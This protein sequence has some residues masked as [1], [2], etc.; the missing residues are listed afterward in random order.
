MSLVQISALWSLD[1]IKDNYYFDTETFN[2][3]NMDTNRILKPYIDKRGYYAV[4]L[5]R[6]YPTNTGRMTNN[7]KY[8]KI[9]ALSIINNGPY[10]LIEHIND[11]PL[12]NNPSN[13]KFSNHRNN[14]ISMFKNGKNGNIDSIYKLI[15]ADGTVYTGT[16]K[17]I[18]KASGIPKG[19]LYDRFYMFNCDVDKSKGTQRKHKIKDFQELSS[20]SGRS[21]EIE[22]SV[23]VIIGGYDD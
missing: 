20:G 1:H 15:M 18:S 6:K 9:I 23:S 21:K 17:E 19:T 16:M 11:N 13:L 14:S 12:D 3:I 5:Q 4:G 7:V 22:Y 8:H 2:I 10:E